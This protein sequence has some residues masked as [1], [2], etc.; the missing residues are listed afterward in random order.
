[1][2]TN[3][4]I[5]L[6]K[7][8]LAYA[9]MVVEDDYVSFT[10]PKT[11]GM[12]KPAMSEGKQLVLPTED[13]LENFKPDEMVI[14]HPLREMALRGPSPVVNVYRSALNK[15]V[16]FVLTVIIDELS[17]LF[18]SEA[19]HKSFTTKQLKLLTSIRGMDKTAKKNLA[20]F[21]R[22][23]LK[24]NLDRIF[25]NIY[26]R[27]NGGSYLGKKYA[28]VGLVSFPPF[29]RSTTNEPIEQ[30]REDDEKDYRILKEFLK[31]IF[32]ECD[33]EETYNFGSNADI[34]PTFT[35][36]ISSALKVTT[37]INYILSTFSDYIPGW[38][39]MMFQDDGLE[40]FEDLTPLA[41]EIKMIP[42]SDQV[43]AAPAKKLETTLI[44]Q[45]VSKPVPPP[46]RQMTLAEKLS[47]QSRQTVQPVQQPQ[48]QQPQNQT[49]AQRMAGATHTQQVSQTPPLVMIQKPQGLLPAI[50]TAQGLVLVD[51]NQFG[52]QQTQQP[53]M[54]NPFGVTLGS[55]QQSN[56]VPG[57]Y[58]PNAARNQRLA[59][60][61]NGRLI[62][63]SGGG[64]VV[65]GVGGGSSYEFA[66]NEVYSHFPG[67]PPVRLAIDRQ[68]NTYFFVDQNHNKW[69]AV[70]GPDGLIPG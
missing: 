5:K 7:N 53:V 2:K 6:Y 27:D 62:A 12:R 64:P 70:Q 28:R 60:D 40:A 65:A 57:R 66:T 59:Y 55:P 19:L 11:D 58:D 18:F 52:I 35:A 42:F 21:A 41:A 31:F 3:K 25:V 16:N 37:R 49:F 44:N 56:R 24:S 36:F 14:F 61:V 38:E 20:S 43:Q 39:E 63:G 46:Q 45:Q 34:A 68:R 30:F 48:Q 33:E 23:E 29:R 51:P 22:S 8:I 15:R 67:I 9:G 13:I 54:D 32:P 26:T 1:M 50:Q 10:M 47:A 17:Q 4:L 69:N